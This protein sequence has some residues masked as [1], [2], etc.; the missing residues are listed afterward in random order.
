MLR[1]ID[2]VDVVVLDGD[3]ATLPWSPILDPLTTFLRVCIA[4]QKCV[5][6]AGRMANVLA[7]V[8]A[9][10][11]RGKPFTVVNG[12]GLGTSL[13]DLQRF[14]PEDYVYPTEENFAFL[15]A[16]SGDLYYPRTPA[17]GLGNGRGQ[18]QGKWVRKGNVG[19][20]TTDSAPSVDPSAGNL[21]S[22]SPKKWGSTKRGTRPG[23]AIK[24]RPPVNKLVDT[25]FAGRNDEAVA[26]PIRTNHF[27]FRELSIAQGFL[28]NRRN[29]V[30]VADPRTMHYCAYRYRVLLVE[31]G[32][33]GGG[34]EG[35]PVVIEYQNALGATFGLTQKYPFTGVRVCL[36][37]WSV[38]LCAFVD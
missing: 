2:K 22:P 18:A 19:N 11:T 28:V 1:E 29:G 8:L 33:S 3:S 26:R 35:R 27:I 5:F 7:F 25:P 12:N 20:T 24:R 10:G 9:D 14:F 4:S 31:Q 16:D 38:G 6:A 23:S 37:L 13:E 36:V 30:A 15:D 17:L 34:V 21:R 32:G